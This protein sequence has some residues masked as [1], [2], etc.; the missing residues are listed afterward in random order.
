MQ[1]ITKLAIAKVLEKEIKSMRLLPGTHTVNEII[2][3]S[4]Q[5]EVKKGDDTEYTPTVEIPLLP[6]LALLLEK[7][8]FIRGAAERMLT[9]AMVEAIQLNDSPTAAIEERMTHINEAMNRARS[10]V[11]SLP[12]RV[13]QGATKVNVTIEEV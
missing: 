8:G 4:V 9:E 10:I 7:M 13:R 11:G 3:I 1:D 2:R 5:G 6:T 12:R